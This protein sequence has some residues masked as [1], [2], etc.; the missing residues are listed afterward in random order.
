MHCYLA[1]GNVFHKQGVLIHGLENWY[2]GFGA[3]NKIRTRATLMMRA[4][5]AA[6]SLAVDHLLR[7]HPHLAAGVAA[8]EL[9]GTSKARLEFEY[10]G[11]IN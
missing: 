1:R 7:G 3:F 11:S 8:K 9:H 6:M 2:L 4:L 5:M 10:D